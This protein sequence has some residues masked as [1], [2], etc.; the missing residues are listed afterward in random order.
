MQVVRKRW[1]LW[2]G[3]PA[4][5]LTGI[6][7]AGL[8]GPNLACGTGFEPESLVDSVRIL[9][10]Q[11]DH[12]YA[13]PGQTVN[14]QVLAYDGRQ[15]KPAPMK[16]WWLPFVCNNP[17]DDLYYACFS[18]FGGGGVD[19]G[20]DAA[21]PLGTPDGGASGL[22]ALK[23][24]VDLTPLLVEGATFSFTVRSDLISSHPPSMSMGQQPYGLAIAFNIACAGHV[25]L[26]PVDPSSPNP[27]QVPVGCFDAN[28]N[29]LGPQ[30]Y[31]I[32]F[33]RVYAY[34][35]LTN[36]NPVISQVTFNG[37]PVDDAGVS[38]PHCTTSKT[39]NC[40][41][42]S[43]DTV[44]PP[45]SQ[46]PDPADLGPDGT[47]RSEEIWVDYFTTAGSLDDDA[48]LLYDAVQGQQTDTATKYHAPQTAGSSMLWAIVHDN[49]GGTA[50]QQIPV[51]LQ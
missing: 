12:P 25:E 51:E 14:L 45:S 38:V 21:N 20:P 13:T 40:P 17:T 49:R 26:L 22:G 39:Q 28:H 3:L 44:V 43:L 31:V 15:I 34:T 37:N 46:E 11:A 16:V 5:A 41:G 47:A 2:S 32:G 33:T 27:L 48:R 4:L 6:A 9:A 29:Q 24:G 1:L 18:A 50:W 42:T 23:P 35:T 7:L 30:D 8:A 19:A 36:A 10:S